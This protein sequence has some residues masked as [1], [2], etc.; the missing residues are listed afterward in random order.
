[1]TP[2]V[3]GA[4]PDFG[5]LVIS[6]DFE[7]LWGWRD[8]F[9][10]DGGTYRDNLLGSRQVIPK[11]LD[12][13][14]RY[15][16]AATWAAVGMLFAGT[17]SELQQFQPT[18]LPQYLDHR[19]CAYQEP[20][21]EDESADPLHFGRT[22]IDAIRVRSRQEIGTHTFSHFYCLEPG[23]TDLAFAADLESAVA[24]AAQ[25][26]LRL[27]SIVFPRNQ[28]NPAF[29]R[30]LVEA[31]ITTFRGTERHTIHRANQAAEYN[32][33]YR[34]GGRLLD[35]YVGLSGDNVTSWADIPQANG[36][37]NVPASCFL[38]P[39]HSGRRSL[40]RLRFRRI[41]RALE[42]AAIAGGIYHLWWHPHNFGVNQRENIEFLTQI[43]EHFAKYRKQYGM[44]SLSMAGVV[45]AGAWR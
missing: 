33:I 14:E 35:T 15:D 26:N 2:A 13:F 39:V 45:E 4:Q 6:L 19:L 11:L 34:R 8:A 25:K 21:G 3:T 37:Y 24:I 22:L 18:I 29:A 36:L 9:P 42:R 23:A 31:G 16:I 43:F 10:P 12:L 28:H 1:M 30:H 44:Q 17:R 40:E 41:T 20:V 32:R 38:R 27:R 5:A 7:L